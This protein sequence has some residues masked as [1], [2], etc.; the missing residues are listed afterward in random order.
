MQVVFLE[1]LNKLRLVQWR[2]SAESVDLLAAFRAMAATVVIDDLQ[3]IRA[4][5]TFLSRAFWCCLP[6]YFRWF[7]HGYHLV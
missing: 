5:Q 6:K 3:D 4:E 1:I 7:V 2:T